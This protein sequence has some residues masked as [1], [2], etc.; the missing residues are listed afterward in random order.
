MC[1]LMVRIWIHSAENVERR[2]CRAAVQ[3]PALVR[4]PKEAFLQ[5]AFQQRIHYGNK[6]DCTLS[7]W[8]PRSTLICAHSTRR[9]H[10]MLISKTGWETKVAGDYKAKLNVH[11]HTVKASS[12]LNAWWLS[13]DRHPTNKFCL[14]SRTVGKIVFFRDRTLWLLVK[15]SDECGWIESISLKRLSLL[16]TGEIIHV[17][18]IGGM[19]K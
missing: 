18:F 17:F 12:F 2:C 16:M 13:V 6:V 14:Y 1:F 10:G 8:C 9:Q 3:K 4:I 15:Y 5:A 11:R 19:I 7:F